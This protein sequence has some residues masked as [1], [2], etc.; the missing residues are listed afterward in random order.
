MEFWND[1]VVYISGGMSY[2]FYSD[3]VYW[4]MLLRAWVFELIDYFHIYVASILHNKKIKIT[5][6]YETLY[7]VNK[8][9]HTTK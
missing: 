6:I 5:N 4:L 2:T 3:A 1:Q 9:F 7:S 8:L